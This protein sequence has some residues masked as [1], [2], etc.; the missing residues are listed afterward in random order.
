MRI[1][2]GLAGRFNLGSFALFSCA[3]VCYFRVGGF[4]DYAEVNSQG[5]GSLWCLLLG[6]VCGRGDCGE[7]GD[8]A[9]QAIA[10]EAADE[11]GG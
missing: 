2:C 6:L 7:L 9:D 8:V 10:V 1:T 11:A 5:H 4:C 3:A